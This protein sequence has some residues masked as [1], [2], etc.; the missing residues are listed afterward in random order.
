MQHNNI[1][2]RGIMAHQLKWEE[3]GV[4]AVFSGFFTFQENN[5][6]GIEIYNDPRSNDLCYAIWDLS[7]ITKQLSLQPMKQ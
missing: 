3:N 4:I 7:G 1:V 2:K 6:A 5:R